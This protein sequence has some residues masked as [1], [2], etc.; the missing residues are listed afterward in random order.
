[1]LWSIAPSL[2]KDETPAEAV[3]HSPGGL[4]DYLLATINGKELVTDQIFSGKITKPGSHGSLEWAVAWMADED[5]FS[6]SYCNTIPTPE[7][8]T[9]ENGLR[10]ALL[11]GLRDH[12]ERVGQSK[13]MTAVTTD[14]VMATCASMLSVFIREPEFQ[15]QTKDKLA[16]VEA[17]RIVETAVRD[18]F[19]HWLA[20]APQQANKLLD[21]VIDRAEERLRRRQEKEVAR[22]SA[23]RKRRLPGTLADCTRAGMSGSELF[24]VE[25]DSAGGSAKQARDRA[26]QAVLP[27]HG[28]ILNV[29]SAGRDKL[30]QNQQLADLTQ[31]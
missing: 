30:H 3:F 16:T 28:K 7:G 8:G 11:R 4:K 27:L 18:A 31:A 22:K 20:A 2:I 19:D 23:T 10:I 13:R 14:D 21:W 9:H 12:A 25:G 1:V 26:T 15:G 6:S 17:G 29:A 5:G 24:I